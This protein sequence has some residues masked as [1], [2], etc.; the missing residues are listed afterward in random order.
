MQLGTPSSV[1]HFWRTKPFAVVA[2]VFAIASLLLVGAQTQA[3]TQAASSGPNYTFANSKV[4]TVAA[5]QRVSM[6]TL[7]Q[8]VSRTPQ[9]LAALNAQ[10]QAVMNRLQ[11]LPK[12]TPRLAKGGSNIAPATRTEFSAQKPA[13]TG[14]QVGVPGPLADGDLSIE[15]NKSVA[16]GICSPDCAASYVQ[17]SSIAGNGKYL[18]QT[19]NW[20][21]AV[22]SNG[23]S[24]WSAVDPYALNANFC[25][26]QTVSYD[27]SR[28]IFIWQTLDVDFGLTG[29][30][31]A[32]QLYIYSGQFGGGC[33]Y[34]FTSSN[35]GLAADQTTDFPKVQVGTDD[36]Y[37]TWNTYSED[38]SA[39]ENSALLRLPT[40]SLATCAGFSFNFIVRSD[41]F[42]FNLVSGSTEGMNFASYW[43][44]GACTTGSQIEFYAW[45]E[46]SGSYGIL[47]LNV[48]PYTFNGGGQNCGSSDAVV[49]N[50][51]GFADSRGGTG[52]YESRSGYR[53]FGGQ[54]ISFAI[55]GGAGGV[56]G[57]PFACI[58]REYFVLPTMTYKGSDVLFSNT[59]GI[60]YPGCSDSPYMGHVA[61][62]ISIGGGT[63]P[64]ND[65]YPS[66]AGFMENKQHP[67]QPWVDYF[68]C[69]GSGNAGSD[70]WGDYTTT[71]SWSDEQH[72]LQV[73]WCMSNNSGGIFSYTAI[74]G[75]SRDHNS[76]VT[77][78]TR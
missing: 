67:S 16:G 19:G 37:L 72:W 25:C 54:V 58:V 41:V 17:E 69:T 2:V 7:T 34:T 8:S 39:W 61:C 75:E 40:S 71:A 29:S 5:A 77:W 6:Q 3:K 59:W 31:N 33:V 26:D 45:S 14:P 65:L 50:W 52:A 68:L 66:T 74:V 55:S 62:T 51:C 60:V 30:G 10:R 21:S 12:P 11:N 36:T 63:A 4:G 13:A 64:A 42:T 57:C 15:Q 27:P 73:D 18:W 47:T 24:S 28:N 48:N 78:I 22:S 49:T 76:Y 32:V 1:A 20:Y 70:R 23:G 46:S 35:I 38:G 53:G 9:Q 56:T 44:N 43:C